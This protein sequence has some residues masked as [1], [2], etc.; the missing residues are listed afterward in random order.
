MGRS[1][2]GRWKRAGD[3]RTRAIRRAS[4]S[5]GSASPTPIGTQLARGR[6]SPKSTTSIPGSSE[7]SGR[8][9]VSLP[10]SRMS[11]SRAFRSS[12]RRARRVR[13]QLPQKAAAAVAGS[14]AASTPPHTTAPV[15][16]AIVARASVVIEH[17]VFHSRLF[18]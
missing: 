6:G 5:G 13:R 14:P 8:S 1:A 18:D 11:L 17:P 12:L 2:D 15:S 7:S 4:T 9:F 3:R 16:D 10:D